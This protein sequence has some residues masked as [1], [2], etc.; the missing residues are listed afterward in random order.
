MLRFYLDAI[1]FAVGDL[2]TPTAPRESR[3]IRR[4]P[5]TEAAP[6]LAPGFVRL[7]NGHDL[8]GWEGDPRIWSARDGT[9]TGQTTPEV[10]VKEN[11]F[12]VWKDEVE[13]FELRLKFKLEG[14][15]SGIYY[16]ARKRP[17]DQTK[18]EALVGTQADFDATGRWT[19]VIMEYTL[20][21]VLAERGQ[22][23]N[24]DENG[25]IHVIATLGDPQALLQWIKPNEW[26]DYTVISRGGHVI[27][28]INGT[29]MSEL[30][31]RDP[32]RLVR[33]WLG[34]QVHTG[35]PMRVQFKDIFLHRL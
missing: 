34:L 10:T 35:P 9:I 26:N 30:D 24:I 29:L 33:G 27:L 8:A 18:G 25:K 11:N 28:R 21:E 12:L 16:H 15:N 22:Q 1:Q 19:G 32:K 31:D 3:P 4:V 20:R 23:V 7:F 14:G 5:G 13:D 17:A 6:G 2:D